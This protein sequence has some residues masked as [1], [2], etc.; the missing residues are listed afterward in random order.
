MAEV[1]PERAAFGYV[2]TTAH[3]GAGAWR[4]TL[5]RHDG[6]LVLELRSRMRPRHPLALLGLP[7]YR[8][9]Q[10]RAHRLGL[11]NLARVE[12]GP[13]PDERPRDN[14]RRT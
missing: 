11:E 12:A 6:R 14:A 1:G 8:L 10:K 2:T 13:H 3:Y 5:S 4:A 7:V 9:F